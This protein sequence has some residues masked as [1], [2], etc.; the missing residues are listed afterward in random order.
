[1]WVYTVPFTLNLTGIFNFIFIEPH[2]CFIQDYLYTPIILDVLSV[3]LI[4]E[5]IRMICLVLF[6]ALIQIRFPVCRGFIK[7]FHP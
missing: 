7:G 2:L 1:M 4:A 6:L 5:L 3:N